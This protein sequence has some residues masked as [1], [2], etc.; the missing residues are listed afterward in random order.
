MAASTVDAGETPDELLMLLRGYV[1]VW[2]A[3][4]PC[5]SV[6]LS[7]VSDN[8]AGNTGSREDF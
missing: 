5:N 6:L 7:G 3:W 4:R 2:L 1:A 8:Q